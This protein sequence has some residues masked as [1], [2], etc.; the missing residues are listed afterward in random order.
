MA[1]RVIDVAEVCRGFN[2]SAVRERRLCF[3]LVRLHT[4]PYRSFNGSAVR[5]RRFWGHPTN[6]S[7]SELQLQWVRRPRT[8]VMATLTPLARRALG[9]SNGSAVR[10][11]RLWT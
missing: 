5:E 10:E 9:G 4:F 6:G 7:A 8:A 1:L 2:G 11:R 3:S